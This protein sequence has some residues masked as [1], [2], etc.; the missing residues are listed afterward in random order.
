MK[1][2]KAADKQRSVLALVI[3][4][5]VSIAVVV[6]CAYTIARVMRIT[7]ETKTKNAAVQ[8]A[9]DMAELFAAADSTEHF[10]ALLRDNYQ[11]VRISGE[12][13][14][15]RKGGIR[16]T[17]RVTREPRTAGTMAILRITAHDGRRQVYSLQTKHYAKTD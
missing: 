9:A 8:T 16:Y 1:M 14:R 3:L 5:A 2:T 17:L 4:I 10:T 13:I 6:C 11:N 15:V 12:T 7:E